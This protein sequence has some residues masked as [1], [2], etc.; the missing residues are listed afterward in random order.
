MAEDDHEFAFLSNLPQ[1]VVLK[2]TQCLHVH[3]VFQCLKVCRSWNAVLTCNEM[4]SFWR[5]ACVHVGLPAYYV[6]EQLANS[7][8]PR[9]LYRLFHTHQKTVIPALKPQVEYIDGIH[10][11]ESTTKCEY[12]GHGYF[13]KTIDFSSLQ[14]EETV[15][16]RLC[17]ERKVIK[18]VD[19]LPGSHGQVVWASI[20]C[21]MVVWLTS[22]Y[23]RLF[24]FN[25]DTHDFVPLHI[26]FIKRST[27]DD[28][29]HCR[30]CLFLV[31][32]S[33][34]N[35][36]H[37]YSWVFQFFRFEDGQLRAREHRHKVAIPPGITQFIPRPV[38]AHLI[39][40]DEHCSSHRLIIQGGT[41][42]CVFTIDHQANTEALKISPKYIAKLNPFFDSDAAVMVVNTTS[43]MTLST[44]GTLIGIVTSIVYPY[45]S[46]LRLHIFDAKTYERTVSVKVDWPEGFNDAVVLSVSE[47]YTV[48]G[49]PHSKGVVKIVHSRSGRIL[50]A[51][52]GL[53]RGLPPVIPV[54]RLLFIHYQGNFSGECL[55]DICKPFTLV[56]LYRKG[57]GNIEAVFFHAFP[58]VATSALLAAVE[59]ETG[60]DDRD[61]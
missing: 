15:V 57:V 42:A 20:I 47:L 3:D 1:D 25:I 49:V 56:V 40:V 30:R 13:V 36:M 61:D 11:F 38:R 9:E 35:A 6:Q 54:A 33:T 26:S 58:K 7:L 32:A 46:G 16:G 39:P 55:V 2:I 44:D 43:E 34:E 10:P 4:S 60:E 24:T 21:D 18:K 28:I 19:S 45:A 12:A 23:T 48:L 22:F 41:G 14:N 5:R 27:G 59:E 37:G 8:R 31:H 52:T 50:L 53:S 17:P 51:T 29:G